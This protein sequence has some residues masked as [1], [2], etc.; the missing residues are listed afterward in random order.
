MVLIDAKTEARLAALQS[1][2]DRVYHTWDWHI[3]DI[4]AQ[5]RE[6]AVE[7][8]DVAVFDAGQIIH[9]A[10]LDTRRTD[11]EELSAGMAADLLWSQLTHARLSLLDTLIVSTKGHRVP[12]GLPA[13]HARDV[14][15]FVDMDLSILGAAPETF[16]AYDAAI[17]LEY[18]WATKDEWRLG[19]SKVMQSFMGR[20]TIF[21]STLYRDLLEAKARANISR[22][23][24]SLAV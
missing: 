2:S 9:D 23:L 19:R 14:A 3:F 11:N 21:Q 24:A 18:G 10:V 5:A 17:R 16:D 13:R 6:H 20:K 1:T 8:S 7:I 4:R 22:L 12:D 15:L